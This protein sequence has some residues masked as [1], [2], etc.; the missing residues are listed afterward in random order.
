MPMVSACPTRASGLGWTV[1]GLWA[2]LVAAPGSCCDSCACAW[3]SCGSCGL[4]G[5]DR[6]VQ[7]CAASVS[8][9][10]DPG[11]CSGASSAPPASGARGLGAQLVPAEP[12][13]NHCLYPALAVSTELS[14]GCARGCDLCSEFN[15]CLRCSPKLFILLERNDIR[16]IGICLPS[17]PLGYFG[18]RNTDMNKCISECGA[19]REGAGAGG[20]ALQGSTCLCSGAG[21]A[22]AV[23][24]GR[25]RQ[26]KEPCSALH[27]HAVGVGSCRTSGQ[28]CYVG[29][30]TGSLWEERNPFR[31]LVPL[32][33]VYCSPDS[34]SSE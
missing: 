16:Q 24:K 26:R 10:Q 27:G 13:T 12:S 4:W 34:G 9:L 31:H 3:H 1:L 8:V 28:F 29:C 32:F 20:S 17:C 15:G 30:Q 5:R 19:G 22:V 23:W 33:L 7:N 6:G 21:G 11:P 14:Q 25:A 2:R 18:L